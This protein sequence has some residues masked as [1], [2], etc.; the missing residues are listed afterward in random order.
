VDP[1][2]GHQVRLELIQIHI[3]GPFE[4]GNM[5]HILR[6]L[7]SSKVIESFKYFFNW[8]ESSIFRGF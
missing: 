6:D 7:L 8:L 2:V 5:E 3:Q 4:S 1:G